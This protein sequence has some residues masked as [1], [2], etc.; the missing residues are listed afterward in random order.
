MTIKV[1]VFESD[2]AFADELRTELN[3][4]GCATTVVDDGN[5]GLQRAATEKPDLI[6]LSI[7]LPRMNGFSVCNKLKKDPALKDVPLIIMSAESSD[8]TFDQHKKLRTRAEDYVHKPIAFAELQ[9]HIQQ[10]VSLGASPPDS[11]GAILVEEIEVGSADYLIDEQG[12]DAVAA[13]LIGDAATDRSEPV[14]AEPS[15]A[16]ARRWQDAADDVDALAETAFSRLTGFDGPA[17]SG[18]DTRAAP[19]GSAPPELGITIQPMGS[20]T[21][22]IARRASVRPVPP[23]TATVDAN[24]HERLRAEFVLL[25]EQTE[26]VQ[27]ELGEARRAADKLRIE[28]AEAGRLGREVD[29]LRAKLSTA[30]KSGGISSR[31]FLDL[32]EALNKKDKE[33]LS[34]REQ[35]S[36]KDRD[37]VES[38]DRALALDRARADLEER[39]LALERQLAETKEFQDAIADERDLAK[40]TAEDMR[41]RF[42]RAKTEG[43]ARERQISELRARNADERVASEV[44][45]AA[46]RAE[47]DQLLANERAEQART[48]D[49]AEQRRRADLD[50][51]RRERDASLAEL[52]EQVDREKREALSSQAAQLWQ[53]HEA[54]IS[55]I[56]R[57][58]G[59]ELDRL[60]TETAQGA[61]TALDELRSRH[62]DEVRTLGEDRDTRIGALESRMSREI[63]E[64]REVTAAAEADAIA[65]RNELQALGERKRAADAASQG[66]IGEL[67]QRLAELQGARDALDQGLA[68]ASDRA[69]ALQSELES[70]RRELGEAKDRVASEILRNDQNR[71]KWDSDRQSLDRA[72]DAL[73]VA[74][75]QIEEVEGRPIE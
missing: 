8:E 51:L 60:R 30:T 71:A 53:E 63:A 56:Q 2:P 15:A 41:S 24:E 55:N 74:L 43:E 33:I 39:L 26:T 37:I 34:F 36:R 7:E 31:D 29:E 3:T 13:S 10:F 35:L 25:R 11:D 4:L 70:L 1:L 21:A 64:A 75:A 5:V 68:A 6:L 47:L 69:T 16:A 40:K 28:A 14:A 61:Q 49:Q 20:V 22:P 32:R 12:E 48:L 44:K 57:A 67:E 9:N 42:E 50:Q 73:A 62:A 65:V 46:V 23:G 45:L 27:R 58:H 52:R 72:K 19:N 59:Q 66:R 38:Q 54:K 17:Q 18:S